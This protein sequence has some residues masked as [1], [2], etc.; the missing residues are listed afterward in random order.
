[1]SEIRRLSSGGLIDRRS[2]IQFR[3]NGRDYRGYRGDTVAS[4]L[5][6]NGVDVIHRSFKY[7][8]PRGIANIGFADTALVQSEQGEQ[9]ANMLAAAAVLEQGMR[10]KSV[11][12]WPTVKFDAAAALQM[13]SALLPSG[14][15][16]KT[17]MWPNWRL[18]EPFIRQMAGFGTAPDT[19]TGLKFESRY[20]HCD[21]LVAGA[22]PAG[23]A[24]ALSAARSG[25]RVVLVDDG[26]RSGGCLLRSQVQVDGVAGVDWAGR[27]VK[28]LDGMDHVTRLHNSTAWGYH[29]G[30][31]ITVLQREP[32]PE[33]LA[34]RNWK[35]WATQVVVAT[36]A[37][38]RPIAFDGND[39]PGV[40]TS[41]AASHYLKLYAAVPGTRAIIFANNDCAYRSILDL[42]EAGVKV[43]AVA[44][45]RKSVSEQARAIAEAAGS[46]VLENHEVR[47]VSGARRV[48]RVNIGLRGSAGKGQWHE[49]DTLCVSGGWN[50]GVHLFS[51]ARGAL[52]YDERIAGFV[53][54][55][56]GRPCAVV[57]GA[58][59]TFD[60]GACLA[61]GSEAGI[62]AAAAAGFDSALDPIAQV[63]KD[64]IR[65]Y[66]LEPCWN[67]RSN[68]R[69]GKAFVDFAGDVTVD[70][71]ELA[72][73]EGYGQIEH[74]KRYTTTGM[75]IDQGK[76]SNVAAIGIVAD[77]IGV[78]PQ[79][80]GTTTFRPPY[81]PVEFGAI[82]G[83]RADR[84]VRQY[85]HTPMTQWHKDAGAVMYEAGARWRRPGYYLSD[86]ST[87]DEAVAQECA[88]VRQSVGVYDGSPL[89]K[90]EVFG[91]DALDLLNLVYTNSFDSLSQGHGQYGI[92][93][94]EDGLIFDDGVVFRLGDQRYL[95]TSSTG[96]APAVEAMLERVINA[97]CP[98][99]Q[100]L[101]T[102]ITS[103]WA[104][105]TVCGPL[106]RDLMTRI[107]SAI[108]FSRAALPHMAMA[109]GTFAGIEAR[110]FRVSFTGELSYEVNVPW[111]YGLQLWTL[112]LEQGREFGIRPVGSEANHVLRVEK[113]YLSLAHEVDGTVDPIDLGM[114]WAID[115][116]K[117]DFV[118][119]R[120]MEMRRAASGSRN[121]LVGLL[122]HNASEMIIEGTPLTLSQSGRGDSAGY[123][124]ACVR[125]DAC[126]RVVAL[127][128]LN[129]GRSR[130][131]QTVY[132]RSYD[133]VVPVAVTAPRFYDTGAQ[134]L[135]M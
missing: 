88:S 56:P 122:P 15:Y 134:R 7:H 106:A 8:R 49:C 131:G 46:E 74:V 4:A 2:P 67:A 58:N 44:D 60:I 23:L 115:R 14:F 68:R 98:D 53:P 59:G 125:S 52:A 93:L 20:D 124:S 63:D 70:D 100:V 83:S 133:R 96:N 105:A 135:A 35:I 61:E 84:A 57:G 12:C 19:V 87:M 110:V 101:V 117:S 129:D 28:E 32:G 22:G 64:P 118:G 132:A 97:E 73:R 77:R 13:F 86:A 39:R 16:Y 45:T 38:E 107:E 109:S 65:E 89:G 103:Q 10:V 111:R 62:Q 81:A 102:P 69:G 1:M 18:F 31:M 128:L 54:A 66:A 76:T 104:N 36:G 3:F 114:K 126:N 27:I 94:T 41:A 48:R 9:S 95:L 5:M 78:H 71:L 17:F 51:Q 79:Q 24:A 25:A 127:G 37:I 85:R 90:F 50:P 112:V 99:L 30:N 130:I 120:T 123:V 92:M 6:A 42:H 80:I 121:E 26:P 82:A 11:N 91:P 34:G 33:D 119:K 72:L 113:G 21:V 47:A 75:G 108:D 29:E 43:A 116:T 55:G 40:L